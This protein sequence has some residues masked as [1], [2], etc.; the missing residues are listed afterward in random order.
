MYRIPAD[1]SEEVFS[2]EV[3]YKFLELGLTNREAFE[4]L[5]GNRI[6]RLEGQSVFFVP[7][8]QKKRLWQESPHVMRE[9]KYTLRA[10]L[11]A[12]P[13]LF[14]GYGVAEIANI[15]R[16]EKEPLLTK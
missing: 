5:F 8:A 6:V 7:S 4:K 9:K 10:K 12:K 1:G 14:G 15:E 3:H 11:R 16:L 13:L 2:G